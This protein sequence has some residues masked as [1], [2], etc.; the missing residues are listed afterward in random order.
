MPARAL[1]GHTGFVGGNI[2][3]QWEF[4]HFYNS[5]NISEIE[6][7]SFD[8]L[9]FAGVQARRWWANL[10]PDKDRA[11]IQSALSHLEEVQADRVVVISTIDCTPP[12]RGADENSRAQGKELCAYGGNRLEMEKWFKERWESRACVVRLP[13]L[14]GPGLKKNALFDLI[15]DNLLEK[16]NPDSIYQFYDL[17]LLGEHLDVAVQHE[18]PLVQLVTEPCTIEEVRAQLFPHREIGSE[19][20]GAVVH[21]FRSVH[22]ELFGGSDG[23]VLMR[24]EVMN[25]LASFVRSQ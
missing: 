5:R 15:H 12:E 21:E 23:Y 18:L 8:L 6:G 1:I 16:V 19:A 4:S 14:F 7:Q 24:S 20:G 3:R 2:Q 22:A 17:S 11:G 9:V 10:H 25:R 13:D